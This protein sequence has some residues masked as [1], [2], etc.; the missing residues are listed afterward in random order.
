VLCAHGDRA[1]SG[2]RRARW[3]WLSNDSQSILSCPPFCH[4]R[5]RA[6]LGLPAVVAQRAG[7]DRSPFERLHPAG[8][9]LRRSGS[10]MK[11]LLSMGGSSDVDT[12]A[13]APWTD[14]Q[15]GVC[16]GGG[17]CSHEVEAFCCALV[18]VFAATCSALTGCCVCVV[19]PAAAAAAAAGALRSVTTCCHWWGR[20]LGWRRCPRRRRSRCGGC[21][22]LFGGRFD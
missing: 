9:L 18:I 20:C 21:Y 7:H 2:R 8:G 11:R 10:N 16:G 17:R 19:A 3:D 13:D 5:A 4:L 15:L 12:A 6:G 22:V 1:R 14:L